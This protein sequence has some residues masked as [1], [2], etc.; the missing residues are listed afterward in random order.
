MRIERRIRLH[1]LHA[2][3]VV[4]V[5][6]DK[7]D[8]GFRSPF[9]FVDPN[10]V[11]ASKLLGLWQ[12]SYRIISTFTDYFLFDSVTESASTPGQ[13]FVYG[14]NQFDQLA[15][16]GWFPASNAYA[17]LVSNPGFGYDD[18][19]SISSLAN[20]TMG[21]CYYL[22]YTSGRF[23]SC[24]PLFGVRLAQGSSSPL[25]LTG[26]SLDAM[27]AVRKQAIAQESVASASV[28][29]LPGTAASTR[30]GA[31]PAVVGQFDMLRREQVLRP[32][33]TSP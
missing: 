7:F 32:A 13:Y 33:V 29:T 20:D 6:A 10:K 12:I 30:N 8:I 22:V 9:A 26:E 14:V 16:G 25:A 1:R 19:Y 28:A 31:P 3:L 21:G 15:V 24:Y 23:S 2:F 18:F 27:L 4:G 17:I 11:L 5:I